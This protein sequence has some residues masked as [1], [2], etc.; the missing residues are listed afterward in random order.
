MSQWWVEYCYPKAQLFSAT[1]KHLRS[2]PWW[3]TLIRVPS[4]SSTVTRTVCA[5]Q[6]DGRCYGPYVSDCCHR[7]CAG[8]C[9]GPKDTDCFVSLGVSLLLLLSLSFLVGLRHIESLIKIRSSLTILGLRKMLCLPI[10]LS[11]TRWLLIT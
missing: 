2:V 5:E 8:G 10:I 7:E 3:L 1:P 9:S 6:C 11:L 4:L